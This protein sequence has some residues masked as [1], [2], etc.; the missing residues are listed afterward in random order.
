MADRATLS[1]VAGGFPVHRV[2]VFPAAPP[3]VAP[4]TVERVLR[5]A[6]E[7]GYAGTQPGR[8]LCRAQLAGAGVVGAIVGERLLTPSA[9]GCRAVA[10]RADRGAG[11]AR[12]RPAAAGRRLDAVRT[13]AGA[14]RPAAAGRGGV[15]HLRAGGRPGVPVAAGA[16]G[17]AGRRRR[18]GGARGA[19]GRH[20]ATLHATATPA[21]HLARARL[22]WD[23]AMVAMPLRLDGRRGPVDRPRLAGGSTRG[24]RERLLGLR[25]V[26]PAAP[27]FRPRRTRSGRRAGRPGPARPLT[28][29]HRGDRQP[30]LA[31]GV[32][33]VAATLGLTVPDDVSVAGFDG[34][35]LPWLEPVRL[36]T[37]VQPPR[38]GPGRRPGGRHAVVRA[39]AGGR[40][41]AGAAAGGNDDRPG[42]VGH[43][44]R[45]GRQPA[46][47]PGRT[48]APRPRSR[49]PGG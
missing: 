30:M 37:V 46:P 23:V 10:G 32:L 39:G 8:R 38:E 22:H 4:A 27:A 42:S 15:R 1:T 33:V 14:A 29:G 7:L 34:A 25:S 26:F 24:T 44:E 16:A 6:D 31:A 17:A 21:R 28:P 18:P 40:G 13:D 5:A 12:R 11:Q 41:A 19:T 49:P 36:T 43:V 48:S 20:S 45:L 35:D 2:A 3:A 9:T 47:G